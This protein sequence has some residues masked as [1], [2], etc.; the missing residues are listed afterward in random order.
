MRV[1]GRVSGWSGEA[2]RTPGGA[3]TVTFDNGAGVSAG[4]GNTEFHD[5]FEILEPECGPCSELVH[6]DPDTT[7]RV[8]RNADDTLTVERK[9]TRWEKVWQG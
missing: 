8:W 5:Y 6:A 3:Y 4:W 9:V 2:T 7:I 1:K